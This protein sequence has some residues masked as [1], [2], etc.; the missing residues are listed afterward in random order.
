MLGAAAEGR[1]K[2]LLVFADDP[3]EFF[4]DLAARAFAGAEFTVVVDAIKTAS[5]RHADIV[6]PGGLLAE[7][8][9]TVVNMEGRAQEIAPVADR[10]GVWTEGAVATF[11]LDRAAKDDEIGFAAPQSLGAAGPEAERPTG[12]RPFIAALD[13]A[14]FWGGHALAAATVSAWREERNLAADFPEGYVSLNREDA[15]ELR[16]VPGGASHDRERR[17]FDRPARAVRRARA[18]R[19]GLDPHV[20]LGARRDRLGRARFRSRS[21]YSGVPSSR[22]ARVTR[23]REL[24]G[25]VMGSAHRWLTR[26]SLDDLL[27]RFARE[28]ALVAPVRIEGEVLFRRVASTE[29]IARDYVNSLVPPKEHFLPTP[30]RL[31]SYRVKDGVPDASRKRR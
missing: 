30:E 26:A 21:A 13:A 6:L 20:V 9:G 14:S 2:A 5:G 15:R 16:V 11:L 31:A 27:D 3:F 25:G 23:R 8:H 29:Q 17:R 1:L 28:G 7:K 4:P 10:R 19:G 18:A 12:E 24:R 22:G